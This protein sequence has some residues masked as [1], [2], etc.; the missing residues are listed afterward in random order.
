METRGAKKGRPKP[1]GSGRKKADP[2]L[3]IISKSVSL[4]KQL[5]DRLEENAKTNGTTKNK[6]IS[7]LVEIYL[8]K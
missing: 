8:K 2:E 1:E 7:N 3:K 6:I 5:W 4:Q